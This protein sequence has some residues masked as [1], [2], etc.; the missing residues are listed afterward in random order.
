MQGTKP[1]KDCPYGY[2]CEK[3]PEDIARKDPMSKFEKTGFFSRTVREVTGPDGKK[4]L[5]YSHQE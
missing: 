1:C 3:C 5:V 4:T 2:E